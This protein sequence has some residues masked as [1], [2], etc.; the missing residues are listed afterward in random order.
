[1]RFRKKKREDHQQS[2]SLTLIPK[3]VSFS[4]NKTEMETFGW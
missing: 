3:K 4:L 1:M 2:Y